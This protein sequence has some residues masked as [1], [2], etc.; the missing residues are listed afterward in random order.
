MALERCKYTENERIEKESQ[1]GA[2]DTAA[3][4]LKLA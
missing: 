3:K 4:I 2:S 1:K